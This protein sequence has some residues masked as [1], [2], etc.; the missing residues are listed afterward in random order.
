[1][2]EECLNCKKN[3]SLFVCLVAAR[4]AVVPRRQRPHLQSCWKGFKFETKKASEIIMPGQHIITAV[5][6]ININ[7]FQF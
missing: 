6:F 7:K 4:V 1:M 2:I 3:L 5:L